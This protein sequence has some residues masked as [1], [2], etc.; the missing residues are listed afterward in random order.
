MR[1]F[2]ANQVMVGMMHLIEVGS[3]S[4]VVNMDSRILFQDSGR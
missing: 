1:K 4:I 3:A 2:D